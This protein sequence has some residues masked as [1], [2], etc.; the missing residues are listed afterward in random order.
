MIFFLLPHIIN[1]RQQRLKFPG[2]TRYFNKT[3]FQVRFL[4]LLAETKFNCSYD[5]LE[6]LDY[7]T[8]FYLSENYRNSIQF[9]PIDQE[10]NVKFVNPPF[11]NGLNIH[12]W[13]LT[14]INIS[15]FNLNPHKLEV[16]SDSKDIYFE[17]ITQFDKIHT[18]SSTLISYLIPSKIGHFSCSIFLKTP[19]QLIKIPVTYR[20]YTSHIREVQQ[21]HFFR[22][23]RTNLFI[24]F[25]IE[26]TPNQSIVFDNALFNIEL[27]RISQYRIQLCFSNLDK[28]DYQTFLNYFIKGFHYTIPLYI[29]I[30]ENAVASV[31]DSIHFEND[32]NNS[33]EN[34]IIQIYNGYR[35]T[36][37]IT[38][39][40]INNLSNYFEITQINS[41]VESGN[42]VDAINIR[43]TKHVQYDFSTFVSLTLTINQKFSKTLIIPIH[44]KYHSKQIDI[45][46]EEIDEIDDIF[47]KRVSVRNVNKERIF[48]SGISV[49]GHL[50]SVSE[51]TPSFVSFDENISFLLVLEREIPRSQLDVSFFVHFDGIKVKKSINFYQGKCTIFNNLLC[52]EKVPMNC[53][54]STNF[55]IRNENNFLITL[56]HVVCDRFLS[57]ECDTPICINPHETAVVPINISFDIEDENQHQ[58]SISL[59]TNFDVYYLF[60]NF[61]GV[62]G[63]FIISSTFDDQLILGNSYSGFIQII[64]NTNYAFSLSNIS[65]NHFIN[66]SFPISI[67]SKTKISVCDI[68]FCLDK[69]FFPEFYSMISNMTDFDSLRRSWSGTFRDNSHFVLSVVFYFENIFIQNQCCCFSNSECRTVEYA[70]TDFDITFSFIEEFL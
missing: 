35:D 44:Y 42:T 52:F 6:S 15:I 49:V 26:G 18:S 48:V 69:S 60:V 10:E 13:Q 64:Q 29:H 37:S 38:Q 30:L 56:E 19:D 2:T 54:V 46:Y 68:D 16:F 55:S 40:H 9:D 41:R 24:K 31:N 25:D 61:T 33:Q 1:A 66:T 7:S 47:V 20:S 11:V 14:P 34:K 27:T 36:A 65:S 53:T 57:V 43:N 12:Q 32:N 22:I 70:S 51:F 23:S 17:K 3:G 21:D 28:G 8:A 45:S 50:F 62:L 58:N 5:I 67:K 39:F 4:P 63:D 59:I